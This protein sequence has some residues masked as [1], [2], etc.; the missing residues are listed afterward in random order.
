MLIFFRSIRC[1]TQQLSVIYRKRLHLYFY[2]FMYLFQSFIQNIFLYPS[3]PSIT[4]KLEI[5]ASDLHDTFS[6]HKTVRLRRVRGTFLYWKLQVIFYFHRSTH[7]TYIFD[8]DLIWISII[9]LGDI[10]NTKARYEQCSNNETFECRVNADTADEAFAPIVF[11]RLP[12]N[13]LRKTF[14]P[15]YTDGHG[16][17]SIELN[18][19]RLTPSQR[20]LTE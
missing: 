9:I 7:D 10:W 8:Y 20:V 19:T 17:Y 16:A 14:N 6:T 12:H 2:S 13:I 15:M 4:K 3:H 18:W 11:S 5:F 1:A